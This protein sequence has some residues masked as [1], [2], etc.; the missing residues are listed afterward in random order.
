M[1]FVVSH[2][3]GLRVTC[4]KDSSI[5][6]LNNTSSTFAATNSGVPQG[7]IL[8]PILFLLCLNDLPN[9][10]YIANFVLYADDT[11]VLLKSPCIRLLY[12]TANRVKKNNP[13]VC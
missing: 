3:H 13:V 7:S 5:Y 1:E 2:T 11:T 6:L 9:S 4:L 8:G 10:S 12:E